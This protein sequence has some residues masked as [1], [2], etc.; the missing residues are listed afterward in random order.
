MTG[1]M[2]S[3]FM[4]VLALLV[5][6]VRHLKTERTV[7]QN[8]S[9]PPAN[10]VCEG[11]V[12]T[13]VCHSVRGGGLYPGGLLHPGGSASRGGWEGSSSSD[14]TGYGQLAGGTHPTGMHSCYSFGRLPP[15]K[16]L[17]WRIQDFVDLG[18][19]P[20]GGG[21]VNVPTYYLAKSLPKTS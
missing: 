11:Y 19:G 21:G 10:E 12:F 4:S 2:C 17:R 13:H 9:L 1:G 7:Q 8:L 15:D 3:S 14:T 16:C 5:H 18:A 20:A 6:G